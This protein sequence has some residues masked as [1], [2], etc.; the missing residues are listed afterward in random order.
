[1]R[2]SND[3]VYEKES[4]M[5][6]ELIAVLFLGIGLAI[7]DIVSLR[8]MIVGH[9]EMTRTQQAIAGLIVQET[10]KIQQ[11]LRA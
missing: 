6:Y 2:A 9:R 3:G 5:S 1:L 7:L 4:E 10:E 8:M 11:L